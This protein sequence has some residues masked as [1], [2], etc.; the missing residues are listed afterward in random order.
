MTGVSV[1]PCPCPADFPGTRVAWLPQTFYHPREGGM[2][3]TADRRQLLGASASV[4]AV[5]ADQDG[6]VMTSDAL[7]P[8]ET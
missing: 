8:D 4:L 2:N 3:P 7:S 1:P 6:S 5:A